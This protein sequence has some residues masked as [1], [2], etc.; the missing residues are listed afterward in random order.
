MGA[1]ACTGHQGLCSLWPW[2]LSGCG[3]NSFWFWS[4]FFAAQRTK[5][6]DGASTPGTRCRKAA[7]ATLCPSVSQHF[8]GGSSEAVTLGSISCPWEGRRGLQLDSL[9]D[10]DCPSA[11]G[12]MKPFCIHH[13]LPASGVGLCWTLCTY[14]PL[15]QELPHAPAALPMESTA[16]HVSLTGVTCTLPGCVPRRALLPSGSAPKGTVASLALHA[17]NLGCWMRTHP[18]SALAGRDKLPHRKQL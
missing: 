3:H 15:T 5:D 11:Q 14:V 8:L 9:R 10:G 16:G 6:G 1:P 18:A 7:G 12:P 4:R 13:E 17:R 2:A